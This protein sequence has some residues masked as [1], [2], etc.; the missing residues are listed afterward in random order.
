MDSMDTA[1]LAHILAGYPEI[2]GA[3]LF[4]SAARGE[5]RPDSDVDLGLVLKDR[6]TTALDCYRM[7]GDLASRLEAL[8]SGRPVDLVVLDPQ[9]PMFR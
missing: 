7:L 6:H 2:A 1:A 9:G 8:T 4:G 3:Y 5:L